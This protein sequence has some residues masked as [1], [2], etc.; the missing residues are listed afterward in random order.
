MLKAD[1]PSQLFVTGTDTD[2]GKTVLSG[3]LCQGLNASYWKP[4]QSGFPTDTETM[5][6][7]IG[8][9]RVLP[10]A[11]ILNHPLSPN[12]AAQ[13]DSVHIDMR[14]IK[15]PQV[16]GP[17]IV[18]GAGGL[19]VPLNQEHMMIDLIQHLN[20]PAVIAARSGLGTLN[21][22]LLSIEALRRRSIPIAGVVLIGPPMPENSRDIAHFGQVSIL[23]NLN[24][25]PVLSPTSL[26]EA[27]QAL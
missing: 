13:R 8:A 5:A 2:V 4:I 3:V 7:W 27:F 1:L 18:E 19:M 10:E 17:L 26:A 14:D 11:V 15:L 25:L 12:Q 20:L 23:G 6:Q 21:H 22:T 9:E 24:T 16:R